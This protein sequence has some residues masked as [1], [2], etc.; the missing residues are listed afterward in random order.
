M[1]ES[2]RMKR[3]PVNVRCFRALSRWLQSESEEGRLYFNVRIYSFYFIF[4]S[5]LH[6]FLLYCL[7]KD[8]VSTT[9]DL[10]EE[11]SSAQEKSVPEQ[12]WF[13]PI[14]VDIS[15]IPWLVHDYG[16]P[17]IRSRYTACSFLR[18]LVLQKFCQIEKHDVN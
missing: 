18:P 2:S 10:K 16:E 17:G 7:Q 13:R 8:L 14:P 9:T 11:I 5:M 4:F 15:D 3:L 1:E 6:V 12:F